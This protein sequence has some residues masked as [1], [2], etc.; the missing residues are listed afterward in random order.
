MDSQQNK[1]LVMQ[2][3]QMFQAGNIDGLLQLFADDT[4]WTGTPVQFVPFSGSYH[5]RQEVGQFFTDMNQA[6]ETEQ[7][8]PQEFVAEGDKVV[9]TGTGKWT[10]RTTGHTYDSA[11]VHIFTLRDGKIAQFQE[12]YDTATARDAFM[13]I[14]A[15]AQRPDESQTLH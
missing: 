14:A 12:Y 6:Q 2:G 4:E 9:V 15:S 7:F 8:S 3:Y 11:W 13:P 1:E 10:V 5:G